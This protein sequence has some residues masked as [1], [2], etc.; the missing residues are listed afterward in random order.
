M[1]DS[2]ASTGF[3]DNTDKQ[4]GIETE[5]KDL[6]ET[7][8]NQMEFNSQLHEFNGICWD[9]CVDRPSS[10]LDSK[11]EKCLKNCVDRFIDTSLFITTRYAQ[12]LQ[13]N[14]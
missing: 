5:L 6:I 14:L 1:S 9:M 4:K 12:L 8:K 13:K 3:D 10:K 11:T 2:F 7:E